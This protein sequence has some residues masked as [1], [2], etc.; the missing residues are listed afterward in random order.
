MHTLEEFMQL[1]PEVAR[2][3]HVL[4][5]PHLLMLNRLSF[6]LA[7]RQRSVASRHSLLLYI[8]SRII[9]WISK[10]SNSLR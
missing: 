1:A 7:E 10:R 3:E 8:D 6:E 4:Q 9:G 5:D 2:P